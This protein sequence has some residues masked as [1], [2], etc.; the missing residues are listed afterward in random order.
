MDDADTDSEDY[1]TDIERYKLKILHI[2]ISQKK[3]FVR[4]RRVK[5]IQKQEQNREQKRITKI[6]HFIV[7]SAAE[8]RYNNKGIGRSR[9]SI[10]K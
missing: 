2:V 4:K 8:M 6:L 5:F 3:Q 10:Q 9:G 7:E 1:Y